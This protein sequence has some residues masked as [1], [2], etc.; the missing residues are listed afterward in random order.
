MFP[1]QLVSLF[2]LS[3]PVFLGL[4]D[5][6]QNRDPREL[7][8]TFAYA[9][10]PAAPSDYNRRFKLKREDLHALPGQEEMGP[11]SICTARETLGRRM[12]LDFMSQLV[13]DEFQ[14]L[15][16]ERLQGDLFRLTFHPYWEATLGRDAR[17]YVL[18]KTELSGLLEKAAPR[19]QQNVA[20]HAAHSPMASCRDHNIAIIRTLIADRKPERKYSNYIS[21]QFGSLPKS[22]TLTP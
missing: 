18:K 20:T 1:K 6:D 13:R 11:L 15:H 16:A 4:D 22:M 21:N 14:V 2:N 3:D 19:L 10:D 12:Q 17:G 8:A 5:K 9:D 7:C